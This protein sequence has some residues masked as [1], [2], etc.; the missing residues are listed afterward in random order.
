VKKFIGAVLVILLAAPVWIFLTQKNSDHQ[1]PLSFLNKTDSSVASAPPMPI[2]S[3]QTSNTLP[4]QAADDVSLK[5]GEFNAYILDRSAAP[6]KRRQ[7]L[8]QLVEAG[9]SAKAQNVANAQAPVPKFP[10]AQNP[11]SS[12]YGY[13]KFEKGLRITAIETLDQWAANG[14]DVLKELMHIRD[15]QNEQD[16]VFLAGLAVAGIQEG[17]PG[18]VTRFIDQAFDEALNGK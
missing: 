12:D 10:Q 1:M 14:T 18:K 3:I 16:L 5:A 9:P 15:N 6:D 11:H 2:T 4:A 8:Q 13:Y 17:R 7:V